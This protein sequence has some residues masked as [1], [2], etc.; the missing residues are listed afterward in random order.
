MSVSDNEIEELELNLPSA[1]ECEA[2]CQRFAE[3]TGTDTA[4]AMFFLQDRQWDLDRALDAYF[5]ETGAAGEGGTATSTAAVSS[6]STDTVGHSSAVTSQHVDTEPHR[7]RLLSWNIDGLDSANLKQRATSVVETIKMEKPHVVFVQEMVP[8]N[9]AVLRQGL[10]DYTVACGGTGDQQGY[11]SAIF[12]HKDHT[13]M[14]DFT[15]LPFYSSTMSRNLLIVNSVVKG[16]PMMLITSH[17]ES[18]RTHAAERMR[19]LT[20]AFKQMSEAPADRT[21]IF[22]GDLNL[23]DNELEGVGGV[24]PSVCDLW[25]ETGCRKEAR[26]TWDTFRNDNLGFEG[27]SRTA[28]RFDR[29][30]LRHCKSTARVKPVYFELIGLQRIPGIQ[31][32]PSDHW[33]ILAHIDIKP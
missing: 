29:L 11:Y 2:R 32:F 8:G 28:L 15:I 13:M 26:Y 24:P 30:Y 10:R 9:E 16:V 4:L 23:R 6:G 17:L 1:T 7:I 12:L 18:T 31:R 20:A 27:R 5:G 22:G 3:V 21:V 19:Q 14:D 25:E 33:G